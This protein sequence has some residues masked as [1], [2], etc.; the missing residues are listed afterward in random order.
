MQNQDLK[1]LIFK[2][3]YKLKIF[4]KNY[5]RLFF[6]ALI[7]LLFFILFF[8]FLNLEKEKKLEI[9]FLDIGQGDS[10]LI[11][12]PNNQ[13]ILIDAGPSDEVVR[14]LE[15]SISIFEKK[16]D[17]II[18]S[19]PDSDHIAGFN[20]LLPKYKVLNILENGDTFNESP[21]KEEV[22]KKVKEKEEANIL[23][24]NCGDKIV[25]G[26]NKE[27]PTLYILHPIQNALIK[28]DSNDNS[29]VGLLIFHE[30]SFLFTGDIG[31]EVEKKIFFNL[32]LCF[33]KEKEYLEE[34]LKNLTVYKA[35][36]HGSNTGN[37]EAFLKSLKPKYSIISAGKD[38]SYGHP[39]KEVL[40]ILEKYSKNILNTIE[41]GNILFKTDGKNLEIQKSK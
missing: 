4:F 35:S 21:V 27:S 31:V 40:E 11:T 2:Y 41:D 28:N 1:D 14:Q 37:S 23:V 19:H 24:A 8:I 34:K 16:L 6:T 30:Y 17:L 13:K 26:E 15:K 20:Y 32:P 25:L 39:K 12:T 7:I 33:P 22:F 5:S 38:N 36:H 9:K 10:I 3:K 18:M 29:I